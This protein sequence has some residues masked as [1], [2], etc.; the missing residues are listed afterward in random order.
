[1]DL[2]KKDKIFTKMYLLNK[3][4]KINCYAL[5]REATIIAVSESNDKTVI[6][7]RILKIYENLL[8]TFTIKEIIN[9]SIENYNDFN[10]EL[11]GN[12]TKRK[13]INNELSNRMNFIAGIAV[14]DNFR[15][16]I[17]EKHSG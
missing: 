14:K 6:L 5:V 12:L 9:I 1:M 15:K 17:L 2:H 10:G 13:V 8:K 7:K 3:Y 16:Q 4:K 11:M